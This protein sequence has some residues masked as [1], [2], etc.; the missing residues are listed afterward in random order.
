MAL[1][2]TRP[3]RVIVLVAG[4]RPSSIEPV[5]PMNTRARKKLCGRNPR[6]A[7]TSATEARV[8]RVARSNPF[9]TLSRYRVGE[10]PGGGDGGDAGSEPVQ[11]IDEVDGV[12]REYDHEDRDQDAGQRIEHQ[13][14]ADGQ[15]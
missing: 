15:P 9:T 12:D 5:S 3:T 7:P 14:P 10:E 4:T 11:A 2:S 13:H 6:Q 8:L 1:G